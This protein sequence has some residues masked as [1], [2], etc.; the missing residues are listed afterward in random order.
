MEK[1]VYF[2]LGIDIGSNLKIQS[3]FYFFIIARCPCCRE[4]K[5]KGCDTPE[6]VALK[7]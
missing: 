1:N 4:T 7:D 6:G 5:M 2:Q 3:Q